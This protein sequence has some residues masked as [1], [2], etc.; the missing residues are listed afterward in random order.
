MGRAITPY[1]PSENNKQL[2]DACETAFKKNQTASLAEATLCIKE[3]A[4]VVL[5]HSDL[6]A[7]SVL[8]NVR[9][10]FYWITKSSYN[11]ETKRDAIWDIKLFQLLPKVERIPLEKTTF[12]PEQQYKI[13]VKRIQDESKV[14]SAKF[15]HV[16]ER[17][18]RLKKE[19]H[20]IWTQLYVDGGLEKL[21]R[22]EQALKTKRD[23]DDRTPQATISTLIS[24]ETLE[25]RKLQ[26]EYQDKLRTITQLSGAKYNGTHATIRKTSELD[27]LLD[28][29]NVRVP[30]AFNNQAKFEK[31]IEEAETS[32][33]NTSSNDNVIVE[34][35]NDPMK[36]DEK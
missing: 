36:L 35:A 22:A 28:A 8:A 31:I 17:S 11:S 23:V 9:K 34:E 7:L 32:K 4:V 16:R 18:L 15:E 27:Q 10:S 26:D 29:I 14:Y 2:L 19:M 1:V 33:N 5:A 13:V 24:P 6:K 3:I 20:Q 30:E 12:S 21:D 25:L